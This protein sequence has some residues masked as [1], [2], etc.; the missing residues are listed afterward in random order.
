MGRGLLIDPA[1]T[2]LLQSEHTVLPALLCKVGLKL[3]PSAEIF[4]AIVVADRGF[5]LGVGRDA[6]PYL[7][8]IRTFEAMIEILRLHN[9]LEAAP[10]LCLL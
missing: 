2:A 3:I 7:K 9:A 8:A 6:K 4:P 1:D 10:S 5:R